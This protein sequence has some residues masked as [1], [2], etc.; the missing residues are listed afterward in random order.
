M[1]ADFHKTVGQG[2]LT[3]EDLTEVRLDIEVTINN[4]PLSY[5][6]EDVQLPTLTPNSFLFTTEFQHTART[7]ALSPGRKRPEKE[8]QIPVENQRRNVAPLDFR[9]PASITRTTP[10]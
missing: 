2:L 7:R 3:W 4:R 1:K 6:E 8:S 10:T 9:V 5:L